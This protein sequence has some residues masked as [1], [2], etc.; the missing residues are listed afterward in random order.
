MDSSVVRD[1]YLL[2]LKFR[3][4]LPSA[5]SGP[6]LKNVKITHSF[7]EFPE[8]CTSTLEKNYIWQPHFGPDLGI[9][10]DLVDQEAILAE[11]K[12]AFLDQSDIK[13][14]SGNVEKGRGKTKQIDDSNKPWWLRNT[15]YME[16]NLYNV[17]K[18]KSKAAVASE[19]ISAKRPVLDY[20]RDMLSTSFINESFDIVSKTVAD[21]I[22]KSGTNKLV[23]DLSLV[24]M[25]DS[26]PSVGVSF[27]DRLHSLVRFDEDPVVVIGSANS[28]GN[29]E[30]GYS[31]SSSMKA[32]GPASKRRK[33]DTG[34]ITNLRE[35]VKSAELSNHHVLEVSLVSP[36]V[37]TT[38]ATTAATDAASSGE[39]LYSWVKDYRM[40]VQPSQQQDLF[41]F[42][43]Q[44]DSTLNSTSN[45]NGSGE[46][47]EGSVQYFPIRARVDM[48]KMNP[49]DSRPH[50]CVVLRE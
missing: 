33:V 47:V 3:N 34:L 23:R 10:I 22:A 35:N 49:E 11:D 37:T 1:E 38:T 28:N 46:V 48:H 20:D 9:K 12:G 24:P 44:R 8:Y 45:G 21:L 43:M 50:D 14:L 13:Y 32:S 40:D 16:N 42:V 18:V 15:T 25:E 41:L 17:A 29:G 5:P 27:A 2:N 6:F 4:S 26:A 19:T 31:S 30:E 39:A 36:L 7:D